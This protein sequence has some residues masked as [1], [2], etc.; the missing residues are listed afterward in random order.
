MYTHFN[1]YHLLKCVYIFLAD[2]YITNKE[3]VNDNQLNDKYTEQP[4]TIFEA[5]LVSE[6]RMT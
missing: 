3:T 2:L 5:I 1:R 6:V 4:N